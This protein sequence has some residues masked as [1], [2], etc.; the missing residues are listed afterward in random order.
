MV[1]TMPERD[2]HQV[3][4]QKAGFSMKKNECKDGSRVAVGAISVRCSFY[5]YPYVCIP[6]G[7]LLPESTSTRIVV[8][9]TDSQGTCG[10]A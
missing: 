3:A 2:E 1:A 7:I 4:E 10:W 5:E 9:S 6:V 8:C